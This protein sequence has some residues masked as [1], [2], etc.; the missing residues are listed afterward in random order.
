[1]LVLK[2]AVVRT[3]G[4]S[5]V[6]AAMREWS[7][8]KWYEMATFQVMRTHCCPDAEALSVPPVF[9]R[10]RLEEALAYIANG[11]DDQTAMRDA[12]NDYTRAVQCISRSGWSDAFGQGGPPYGGELEFFERVLNRVNKARGR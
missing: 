6:T 12:L 10:C 2:S 3:G 5:N 7:R 9:A 8:L 4:A 1:M 11:I